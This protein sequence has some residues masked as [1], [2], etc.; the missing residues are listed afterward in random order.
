MAKKK[1]LVLE[2]FDI[3][4]GKFDKKPP[5]GDAYEYFLETYQLYEAER[6]IVRKMLVQQLSDKD[7][8]DESKD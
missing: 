8:K 3:K 5:K 6:D 2:V 1:D 7:E 4:T